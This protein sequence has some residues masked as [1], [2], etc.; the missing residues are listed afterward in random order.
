MD[1]VSLEPYQ[2]LVLHLSCICLASVRYIHALF[3][4]LP[5]VTSLTTYI[6]SLFY[7]V[8]PL[9]GCSFVLCSPSDR[10]STCRLQPCSLL[11]SRSTIHLS[12]ATLFSALLQIHHLPVCYSIVFCSPSDLSCCSFT[13]YSPLDLLLLYYAMYS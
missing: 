3:Y 5:V 7:Q 4:S 8:H 11:S 2:I 12:A 13:L 6:P 9:V 1:R 10:P